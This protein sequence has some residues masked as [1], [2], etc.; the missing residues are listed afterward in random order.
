MNG[1]PENSR[2][3]RR[4]AP[5]LILLG[6]LL[7]YGNS[8]SVPFLFDDLPA[9][10]ENPAIRHLRPLGDVLF[11]S[12]SAGGLT[13][14]GRPVLALSLAVNYALGG[15]AV[16]GYHAVNWLVH[17]AA[18]LI[19][20]GL[21]RRTL[22]RARPAD[23]GT[24]LALAIALLW[25]VHPLQTESVTYVVQRAEALVG[26]FYL[27][28]LYGFARAMDSPRPRR[29][30]AASLVAC[31]LG[32][33]AKEVMVTAPVML[34]FYDRT[35]F[36]GSF[37]G[38][39]RQRKGFYAG[40]VATWLLLGA[41]VLST[42]GNR[43][44]T[45]GFDVGVTPWAY[46]LTQ[47]EAMTRY[48]ML[49]VWPHP[50]VFEFGTFWAGG[51]MDVVP[52]AVPVLAL[53]AGTLYA[54]WRRPAW[55]FLGAW[56][57]G[58]LAPTSLTPGTIQMI[59]EHRMYL[60]L[61]AVVAAVVVGVHAWLGRRAWW[62]L[63]VAGGACVALTQARNADYR[64][65]LVLW[66]DTVAKRP[67][68][69]I[70]LTNL[71]RALHRADRAAEALTCYE[72]ALAA[73]PNSLEARFN[74]GLALV[75]LGRAQDAVPLFEAALRV[76]PGRGE[77]HRALGNALGAVGRPAEAALHYAAAL[78]LNPGLAEPHHDLGLILLETGRPDE[79]AT[80]FETALRLDP[81]YA[82]ALYD[83]GNA[84]AQ[85]GRMAEAVGFYERAIRAQPDYGAAHVNLG[86][87]LLELERAAE[88]VAHYEAALRLDPRNA[89][90]HNNLGTVL[91][92]TGRPAEAA[93]HFERALAARPDFAGARQN[94]ALARAQLRAP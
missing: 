70:A 20:F 47:F 17:V 77:I 51:A 42:G 93:A 18:G 3:I 67:H 21:V 61:A 30:L 4:W 7:S 2:R 60:P 62:L 54:L 26:L 33:G 92:H 23:D 22:K 82:A 11:P 78:R 39:L 32:M 34:W 65:D 10:V 71:G 91:L 83:L 12:A 45:V 5:W 90:A 41:L 69:P 44:G 15:N 64:S 80:E 88:A 79:A 35:F 55:G 84:R 72:R 14:S 8:F 36:A 74:L 66:Q 52:W 40:L 73:S 24:L 38:A 48:L 49:S 29:W 31:A 46:G 19:L 6:A 76:A 13:L 81:G 37:V 68:N 28:T 43:G 53:V 57:F 75:K 87:A 59:V 1:A 58:I 85:T 89:D 27:L 56:F 9:I 16:E 94:L 63:G 25:T 50:L 86:N